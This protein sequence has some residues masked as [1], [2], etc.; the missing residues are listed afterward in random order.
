[1]DYSNSS[2]DLHLDKKCTDIADDNNYNDH[3]FL[4]DD[5]LQANE[6]I[7]SFISNKHQFSLLYRK[8]SNACNVTDF[9]DDIRIIYLRDIET[10]SKI[11]GP[12]QLHRIHRNEE[13]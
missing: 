12:L 11:R 7:L 1:M 13:C 6:T 2:L 9:S 3:E 4:V 8:L 5:W 10:G